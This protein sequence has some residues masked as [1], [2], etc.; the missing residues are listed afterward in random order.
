[1]RTA[2]EGSVRPG[3]PVS[4]GSWTRAFGDRE[5]EAFAD[6][7]ATDVLLEASA[8]RRSVR[9]RKEVALVLATASRVYDSLVFTHETRD[10]ART[11]L[12]WEASACNGTRLLGTTVLVR[13]EAGKVEHAVIQH[14][15]LTGLLVFSTELGR[16]LEGRVEDGTF[17]RVGW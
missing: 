10:G 1:M 5:E 13:D 14:R 16:L 9:G 8:L 17:L 11:Y 6:A 12:E 3:E 7:L 4:D 2:D 15:P